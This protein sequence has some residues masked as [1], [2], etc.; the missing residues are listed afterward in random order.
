MH[1]SRVLPILLGLA[2]LAPAGLAQVDYDRRVDFSRYST[3]ALMEGTPAPT[4]AVQGR[5]EAA[6]RF[7]VEVKGLT[8]AE[9]PDLW[10]ATHV[11]V[12]NKLSVNATSFGYGGYPGWGGWGGWGGL[13]TGVYTT[14]VNVR[15]IPVGQLLVDLVDAERGEL[16]WRGIASGTVRSS[17]EKSERQINK[18]VGKMFKQFPPGKK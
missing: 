8:E 5:I 1:L 14:N 17:P 4:A 3:Y 16:V 10:I 12:G 7:E 18:K 9:F 13:S 11:S 2:L 6:I 15:E